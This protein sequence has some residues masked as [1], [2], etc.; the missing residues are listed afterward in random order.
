[1]QNVENAF[2]VKETS[3]KKQFCTILMDISKYKGTTSPITI[4]ITHIKKKN[5][6]KHN[7]KHGLQI[8]RKEQK[9]EGKEKDPK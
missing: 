9:E 6:A 2:E 5:Q 1:M 3:K 8:T 4:M 7:T